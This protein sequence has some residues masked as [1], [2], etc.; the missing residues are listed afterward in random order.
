M[1][2]VTMNQI[3]E[4]LKRLSEGGKEIAL[5]MIYD[6]LGLEG[7]ERDVARRQVEHLVRRKEVLRVKRGIYVYNEKAA[8]TRNGEGYIRIWRAIRCQKAGFSRQDIV[9][10]SRYSYDFVLRYMNFLLEEGYIEKFGKKGRAQRFRL[11]TK[12]REQ[13]ETPY[14]P[15][16]KKD[17]FEEEKRAA[18]KIVRM[19]FYGNLHSRQAKEEIVAACNKLLKRFSDAEQ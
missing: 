7:G 19:F 14:P 1:A 4:V 2:T 17:P 10:I 13:T 12:G 6:A 8:P 18:L 9:L 11:T 3:R 15:L 5:P 16:P